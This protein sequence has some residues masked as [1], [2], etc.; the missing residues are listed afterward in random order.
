M[1]KGGANLVWL[2]GD[3]ARWR[4]AGKILEA[5]QYERVAEL[6]HEAQAAS[7][8]TGD[9]NLARV[10]T[11]AC[12][13]CLECSQCRIEVEW[14][15]QAHE[16][17]DEREHRLRQQLHTVLD[18]IDG[19]EAP[20]TPETRER[21]PS[22]PT[23]ETSL[24]ECGSPEPVERLSLWQRIQSLLG[25]GVGPR[26]PER[27]APVTFVERLARPPAEK[28]GTLVAPLPVPEREAATVSPV[29]IKGQREQAPPLLVIYCLG[30][31]RVYNNEQLVEKWPGR[32]CKSIFKY[33]ITHREPP[34]HREILMDLFWRDSDPE[35]AR[36]NLYQAIY[37]LRQALQ[38]GDPDFPYILREESC[39]YLNP[40][41]ELWV[42]S[43]AFA[44]YYQTGQRLEREGRLHEAVREY[45]MADN[46]YEGEFLAEDRYEDWPLVQ[47]ENLK[48]AHLDI[49]DRLSQYYFD[50]AQ[51]AM[52]SAFCQ[53]ILTEDNCREDAHRRLMRCYLR[54]GQRHL[55][56]RQY[57]LCVEV[58]KRELDVPPMPATIE[59]Y[60]KIQKNRVQFPET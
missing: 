12:R 13:I 18:L 35:A 30:P 11:V 22:A 46:L 2:V 5:R 20:E 29:E 31:F 43:E 6:L 33:M 39:Y 23:V 41:V 21:P 42:D 16:E 19:R 50:Q 54:Q 7:E 51:F 48:H 34:V 32:K 9:A 28:A 52:C 24:P 27:E 45:E 44:L 8:Q 58:L 38:T 36:R 53:K 26:P 40:D 55:A 57:H 47:R 1:K 49:L 60:R 37:N 4:T 25:R 56:L 3:Q 59:L 17:A 10:L 14:H 15:R